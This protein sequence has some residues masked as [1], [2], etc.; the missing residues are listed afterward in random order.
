M[1]SSSGYQTTDDKP[2]AFVTSDVALKYRI[3]ER[4][5]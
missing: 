3:T 2:K 4:V 5:R 1:R